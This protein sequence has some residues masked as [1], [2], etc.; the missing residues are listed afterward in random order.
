ALEIR[1]EHVDPR[2]L[3]RDAA[4]LV[5]SYSELTL[6]SIDLGNLLR[7][8]IVFIRTHPL[9]IPPDLVILIRSLVTIEGVGRALDPHFDIAAQLQPFVS[10]MTFRR[11]HTSRVLTQTVRTGEDVQRIAMLLPDVLGQ[12]LESI[13]RGELTVHF[14]LQ[15][16]ERLVHR[17]TRAGNTLAVGIVT[18][19][20]LVGSALI[21]KVGAPTL[22]YTGLA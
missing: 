21:L 16:F 10:K 17:L 22:A 1:G 4:E 3:R 5:A 12:S 15:H 8:L 18:A 6:D 14:D 7:E 9:H 13:K 11:F 2:A 19:G 20:L